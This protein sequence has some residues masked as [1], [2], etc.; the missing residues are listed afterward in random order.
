MA[1]STRG[2][3]RDWCFLRRRRSRRKKKRRR[4]RNALFAIRKRSTHDKERESRGQ[5]LSEWS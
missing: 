2:D 5:I 1:S 4:R 3:A